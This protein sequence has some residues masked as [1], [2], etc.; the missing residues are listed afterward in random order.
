[1]LFG[2]VHPFFLKSGG[3]SFIEAVG[4]DGEEGVRAALAAMAE[5]VL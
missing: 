5:V 4:P 2:G 3:G 1:M